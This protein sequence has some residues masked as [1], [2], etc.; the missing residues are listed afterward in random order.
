MSKRVEA[1]F[2]LFT[3]T[4]LGN[5]AMS[6]HTIGRMARRS[7]R[8]FGQD[9]YYPRAAIGV[10]AATPARMKTKKKKI[11]KEQKKTA[12]TAP[13]GLQRGG[14]GASQPGRIAGL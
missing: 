9:A 13:A 10:P 6:L 14:G 4:P 1:A 2:L 11:E 12:H 7:A 5:T 8:A 3:C